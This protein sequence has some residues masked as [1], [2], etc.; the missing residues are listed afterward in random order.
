[1]FAGIIETT[2][3]VAR[4]T[5]HGEDATLSIDVELAPPALQV[6]ESIA[7]NGVCLTVCSTTNRTFSA[8]VSV[9][10]LRRTTLG[11]LGPGDPANLE[12][13]LR[14][15]DRIS[16]HFVFGH[17][18]CVGEVVRSEPEG[19][20][21]RM[22]FAFPADLA[23]YVAEKGSIAVDGVSLTVCDCSLSSFSVA[24]IPHTAAATTLGKRRPGERVN[25]EADMLARYVRRSLAVA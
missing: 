22:W 2:G 17:V 4:V 15:G 18:D 16:G 24:V 8:D 12:R 25:L 20:G 23:P 1:V 7:T 9:E 19:G 14:V 21:L 3:T 6:G 11:E 10:T 13:S 5:R